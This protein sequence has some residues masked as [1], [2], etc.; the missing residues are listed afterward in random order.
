M[1]VQ[2]N[3]ELR[4]N[5][6]REKIKHEISAKLLMNSRH[7]EPWLLVNHGMVSFSVFGLDYQ[8]NVIVFRFII[9]L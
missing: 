3:A 2:R 8:A 5:K 7:T 6:K 4:R 1:R 9:E